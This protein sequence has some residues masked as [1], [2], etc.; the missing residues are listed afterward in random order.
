MKIMNY[1]DIK[2]VVKITGKSDKTIRRFLSKNE[3]KPY[4]DNSNG[5]ILVDV[6]YIM[7]SF[8]IDK[9]WTNSTRQSLDNG[10]EMS[11]DSQLIELK[12]KLAIYEQELRH[13]D[14]LLAEKEGRIGDLQKA[15]L[16]LN[17]PGEQPKKKK[18]WWWS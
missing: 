5:K 8:P 16:L 13:K 7:S 3:S 11:M 1:I 12:N 2:E 14:E 9:E 6:N 15:M 17:P 10:Q 18:K 4:L